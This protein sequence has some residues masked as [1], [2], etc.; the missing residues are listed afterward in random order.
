MVSPR[1][2]LSKGS[3][4][5][6]PNYLGF[7]VLV[8]CLQSHV[9]TAETGLLKP[10]KRGRN[11]ALGIA[12][13][14]HG[15]RLD[16]PR[17]AQGSIDVLRPKGCCQAVAC[18]VCDLDRFGL[19]GERNRRNHGSEDLISSDLHIISN[20]VEDRGRHE[21]SPGLYESPTAS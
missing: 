17:Q 21:V 13:H 8:K 4:R 20:I 19:G 6:Y 12:I 2:G 5:L 16:A 14:R 10:T 11:V 3:P 9:T 1:Q 7:G 18:I 15:T